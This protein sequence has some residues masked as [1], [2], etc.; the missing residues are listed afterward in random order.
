MHHCKDEALLT[1]PGPSRSREDILREELRVFARTLRRELKD[2]GTRLQKTVCEEMHRFICSSDNSVHS[3]D[4]LPGGTGTLSHGTVVMGSLTASTSF[5]LPGTASTTSTSI[6][7]SDGTE[8]SNSLDSLESHLNDLAGS[9]SKSPRRRGRPVPP[10]ST[11]VQVK[12]VEDSGSGNEQQLGSMVTPGQVD[13]SP[14]PW[15]EVP[16]QVWGNAPLPFTESLFESEDNDRI[17]ALLPGIVE[18]PMSPS[19][20]SV[21]VNATGSMRRDPSRNRPRPVERGDR[22]RSLRT[23]ERSSKTKVGIW[24]KRRGRESTESLPTFFG[25]KKEDKDV[26]YAMEGSNHLGSECSFA[27]STATASGWSSMQ[28]GLE[29]KVNSPAFDGIFGFLVLCHAISIGCQTDYI[30][31]NAT[32]HIPSAFRI[33]DILFCITFMLELLLRICG[34]GR[35]FVIGKD[36][37]WNFFDFTM[38]VM[39]IVEEV[40][41]EIALQSDES[42]RGSSFSYLR[43]LRLV[44][45]VR[46]LRM[47]RVLRFMSELRKLVYSIGSSLQSLAWT[48][49]LIIFILYV[50]AVCFTQ[51]VANF[52]RTNGTV[53]EELKTYFGSLGQSVLSLFQAMSGGVDWG[54]LS[55][56]LGSIHVVL[57]LLFCL[58]MAFAVLAMMNVV[59]GVFVDSAVQ[60]SIKDQERDLATRLREF[61]RKTDIDGSGRITWDEFE[62]TL[63]QK[64]AAEYFFQ[65]IGINIVEAKSLFELLDVNDDGEVDGD[66]FVMGCMRLKGPAK[67]VD[68]VTLMYDNKRQLGRLQAAC[69]EALRV[70]QSR[71]VAHRHRRPP[72]TQ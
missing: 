71:T 33:I 72:P 28:R 50:A 25:F 24:G 18:L 21:E 40:T 12:S 66:E 7:K 65:N 26:E 8:R 47:V 61:Y 6:R 16:K 23:G 35:D 11:K 45:L 9:F 60:S 27:T 67:S 48:I 30:A 46:V 59:T 29:A 5:T 44:R 31:R 15:Q 54:E 37:C 4:C 36:W 58:Y 19:K 62:H 68:L 42:D 55:R 56:P 3:W 22:V 64:D 43:L 57:T 52:A 14:R 63:K 53:P 10:V 41:T 2:F 69:E 1:P 39:Q 32:D 51:L 13:S 17:E 38:V 20:W 49:L 70:L 34:H